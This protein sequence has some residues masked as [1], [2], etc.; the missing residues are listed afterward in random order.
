MAL[1]GE[2]AL[3]R[4][5]PIPDVDTISCTGPPEFKGAFRPEPG[6]RSQGSEQGNSWRGLQGRETERDQGQTPG[7]LRLESSDAPLDHRQASVLPYGPELVADV[8]AATLPSEF[9]R[10]EVSASVLVSRAEIDTVEWRSGL[11]DAP[12]TADREGA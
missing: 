3:N 2:N 7:A 1:T 10:D 4:R 5:S 9:L 12:R 11:R 8:Q 6:P